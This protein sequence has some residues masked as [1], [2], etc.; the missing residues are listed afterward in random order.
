[1]LPHEELSATAAEALYET[2]QTLQAII[3]ASP[4]AI[5]VLD[6]EGIVKLWNAAAERIYGWSEAEVLNRMLPTVPPAQQDELRRNHAAALAGH[7]FN[8]YE[9]R[10]RRKDGTLINI[11]LTVSPIRGPDGKIIGASKIARDI[12]DKKRAEKER[13]RLLE[14]EQQ[15]RAQAEVA[16]EMHRSIEERLGLLV[17]ASGVLLGSCIISGTKDD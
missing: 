11:S 5:I 10:R 13:E 1:M 15:A 2:N 16:L 8:N 4:L 12:T 14:S 17:E 6:R 7:N 3:Q 9:T